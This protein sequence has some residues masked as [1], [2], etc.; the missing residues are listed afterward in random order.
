MMVWKRDFL[1][2]IAIFG[3]YVSFREGIWPGFFLEAHLED[4]PGPWFS[5]R[6]PDVMRGSRAAT[7]SSPQVFFG[8]PKDTV[9]K[10]WS[11]VIDCNHHLAKWNNISPT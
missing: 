6:A 5:P 8:W 1:S 11:V 4:L 3:I 9:V 2:N 10:T 7:P